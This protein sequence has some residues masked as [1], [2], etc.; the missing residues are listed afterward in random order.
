MLC[1]ALPRAGPLLQLSICPQYVAAVAPLVAV[2][3]LVHGMYSAGGKAGRLQTSCHS[4]ALGWTRLSD[5][6][7]T[8]LATQT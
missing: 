8:L 5:C 1:D 6:M 3:R 4:L 7:D 2:L